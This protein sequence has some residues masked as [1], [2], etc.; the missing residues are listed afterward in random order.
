MM[1]KTEARIAGRDVAAWFRRCGFTVVAYERTGV[2]S[3]PLAQTP[4]R[5]DVVARRA[6]PGG[7]REVTATVEPNGADHSFMVRRPVRDGA[8]RTQCY[9]VNDRA[10][11][12]SACEAEQWRSLT[13]CDVGARGKGEPL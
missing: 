12:L 13:G 11:V 5:V 9:A 2:G 6:Y 8:E 3:H 1:T 10:E 7:E 4:P